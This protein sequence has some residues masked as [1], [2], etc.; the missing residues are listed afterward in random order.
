MSLWKVSCRGVPPS[1]ADDVDLAGA[2]VLAGEGDRLAV[3]RE[4]GEELLPLARG[5][6]AGQAALGVGEP[7]VA[8]VDEGDRVLDRCRGS[9]AGASP[10]GG[11]RGGQRR[12]AAASSRPG[13]PSRIDLRTKSPFQRHRSLPESLYGRLR[14]KFAGRV[15]L[16]PREQQVWV[17][18]AKAIP[19]R[20][21]ARSSPRLIACWRSMKAL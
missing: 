21:K 7:D 1:D 4:L 9:A 2:G 19:S 6:A 16:R 8:A 15:R 13:P 18:E 20:S 3:R 12:P 11:L 5:Q 17:A 10:P 14:R